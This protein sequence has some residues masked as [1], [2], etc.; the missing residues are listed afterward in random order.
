MRA[1]SLSIG[2]TE[3]EMNEVRL[4]NTKLDRTQKLVDSLVEQLS[5]L[6]EEVSN[7]NYIKASHQLSYSIISKAPA[8]PTQYNICFI[9]SPLHLGQY[10][11][12]SLA[13]PILFISNKMK[14]TSS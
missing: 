1:M 2:E 8:P 12:I 10:P 6:K 11:R 13:A 14:I 7:L 4:L 3:G 9:V 5:E